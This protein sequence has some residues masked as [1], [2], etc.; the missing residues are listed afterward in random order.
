MEISKFPDRVILQFLSE[1]VP[2][3]E[4]LSGAL[5][6]SDKHLWLASDETTTLERLS[7]DGSQTFG[8]H[9]QI[10]ISQFIELPAGKD[11]EIDIEGLAY[12]DYYL[13]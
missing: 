1:C 10:D 13:W 2:C 9:K 3:H 4:D 12:C 5:L 7:F 6:T 8:N 11:E